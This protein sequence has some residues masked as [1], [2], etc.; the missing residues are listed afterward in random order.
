MQ[1]KCEFGMNAFLDN[2]Y[3][4]TVTEANIKE[5]ETSISSIAGRHY[6]DKNN[7][8]VEVVE[9]K[10]TMV[11]YFPRNLHKVFPRLKILMIN[12]CGL[13][14]INHEDL[15]GLEKLTTLNLYYNQLQTLPDNL[16]SEMKS[17]KRISFWH[18]ELG[19]FSSEVLA[20]L[21]QND[22]EY[23]EFRDNKTI[24]SFYLNEGGTQSLGSV[25][26][27]MEVIDLSGPDSFAP[28]CDKLMEIDDL[29]SPASLT[30]LKNEELEVPAFETLSKS[31]D[32]PSIGNQIEI[33]CNFQEI[34]WRDNLS[35]YTCQVTSVDT[36][37][38]GTVIQSIHGDH[39]MGKDDS[40]VHAIDID[41]K[42][43]QFFP[44]G[45]HEVFKN[46]VA[47]DIEKCE[48]KVITR[49]DLKGLENLVQFF[50]GKNCLTKLPDDLFVGM[51]KLTMISFNGNKIQQM[52]SNL[53]KKIP[54]TQL[55]Y[56]DFRGNASIDAFFEPGRNKSVG[57]IEKLMNIIDESCSK[58]KGDERFLEK[59]EE[60]YELK[61]FTDFTIIADDEKEFKV[62][63][64]ILACHSS[65]LAAHFEDFP[66]SKEMKI[67][68]SSE[69]VEMFLRFIYSKNVHIE[70]ERTEILALSKK[71][72]VT[73]LK[74]VIEDTLAVQE[75][76]SENKVNLNETVHKVEIKRG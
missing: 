50:V 71:L 25:E 56:V 34:E 37:H 24:N 45:I 76:L 54:G 17:L 9:F 36:L 6:L 38:R 67:E 23:L 52:S 74:D 21:V 53:L 8:D 55:V 13:Q 65:V 69:T 57:S 60:I 64:I 19:K 31:D 51:S 43:M 48:L 30:P 12:A 32:F 73:E 44:R 15:Q 49:N 47:L 27:L 11:H 18:N 63:K 33:N 39:Q 58:S 4:C 28:P 35:L 70:V 7:C 1:L 59:L 29:Q 42:K 68:F 3:C 10:N 26:E 14:E 46:L 75:K 62:Q 5:R 72:D 41:Q 40:L 22:V 2:R 66:E 16:F 20:P 61:K